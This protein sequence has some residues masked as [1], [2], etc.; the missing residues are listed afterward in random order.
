M[1]QI[2]F[3]CHFDIIEHILFSIAL[4][5]DKCKRNNKPN[6]AHI[7]YV[8]VSALFNNKDKTI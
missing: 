2:L 8:T 3:F 7:I 6:I 4:L 5:F 1:V